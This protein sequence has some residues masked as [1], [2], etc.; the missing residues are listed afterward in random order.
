[1]PLAARADSAQRLPAPETD[2]IAGA[3]A[4][5]TILRI[6]VVAHLTGSALSVAAYDE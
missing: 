2:G 4:T 5:V 6:A 3:R 1:M